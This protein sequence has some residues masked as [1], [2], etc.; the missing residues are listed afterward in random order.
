MRLR[1]VR[2]A[3]R[4][5]DRPARRREARR[6]RRRRCGHERR[7]STFPAIP[8]RSRSAP[9]R[10][11]RRSRKR[12]RR[13]ASMRRSSATVRAACIWLEP[14]VEVETPEA[15]SPTGRSRPRSGGAVRCRLRRWRR[16]CAALGH[17]EEMPFLA[18]QTR[19]TFARCGIT[20]PLS[21]DDY[22]A[23]GGLKGLANALAMAPAEIVE[24]LPIPACAAAAAPV[25]RP[26]SNGRRSSIPRADRNTSSAMPTRAIA[27]P[28]P[29]A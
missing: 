10:S 20:D 8:A 5:G 18:R 27:A 7:P 2:H 24:R 4:R 29:T 26:A 21:L 6:N 1:A 11:R 9:T 25:S 19:L 16:A 13:A 17:P 15:A 23:H 28:S 3:R 12:S 14:M 22:R